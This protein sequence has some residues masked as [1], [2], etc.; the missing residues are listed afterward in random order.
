MSPFEREPHAGPLRTRR[1]AVIGRLRII[2]PARSGCVTFIVQKASV[3]HLPA[4]SLAALSG[5]T[6]VPALLMLSPL[7]V[8]AAS[9]CTDWKPAAKA[10]GGN[11]KS[12]DGRSCPEPRPPLM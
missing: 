11:G 2:A 5:G 3:R 1:A 9:D 6:L 10:N 8:M 4:M 7:A 12:G